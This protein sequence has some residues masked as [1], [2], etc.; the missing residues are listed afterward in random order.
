MT[1]L[2]Q[3]PECRRSVLDSTADLVATMMMQTHSPMPS[4]SCVG[5]ATG[6]DRGTVRQRSIGPGI[7]EVPLGGHPDPEGQETADSV[8]SLH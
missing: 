8:R 3:S 4:Q 7:E 6:T 5:A 2:T 1:R